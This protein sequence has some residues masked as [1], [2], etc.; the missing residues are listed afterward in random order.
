MK[1]PK[2]YAEVTVIQYEQLEQLKAEKDIEPLDFLISKLSI[3][4]GLSTDEIEQMDSKKAFDLN[5]V[6]SY[7]D[8]EFPCYELKQ[9]ITIG[10]KIFKFCEHLTVAQE[11]DVLEFTRLNNGFGSCLSEILAVVFKE[12]TNAGYRYISDNH[13][14][15]VELFKTAKIKDISGVVFFYSKILKTLENN[16]NTYSAPS[17]KL[18]LE[19]EE[20][21]M[22][23]KGFQDFLNS[24]GSI[25]TLV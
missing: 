17:K 4:T 20:E 14:E 21:M 23:D 24:G 13:Y 19:I 8:S 11:R 9:T 3:L 16:L 2:T 1:T 7:A 25:T 6:F 22:R 12:K 15:N 10:K 5:N 18:I